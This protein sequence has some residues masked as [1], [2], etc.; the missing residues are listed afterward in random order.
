MVSGVPGRIPWLWVL[1]R[2]PHGLGGACRCCPG[3]LASSC[4]KACSPTVG[5]IMPQ[6]TM[7]MADPR[8]LLFVCQCYQGAATTTAPP[9]HHPCLSAC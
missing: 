9:P 1:I 7:A 5:G 3:T 2:P 8:R 6:K 4:S